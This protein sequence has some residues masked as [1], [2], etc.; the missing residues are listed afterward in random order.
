LH[1]KD[2]NN[3]RFVKL[4]SP[5]KSE[6]A[7]VTKQHRANGWQFDYSK[8][9]NAFKVYYEPRPITEGSGCP[10][11][12][13]RDYRS[14]LLN[15]PWITRNIDEACVVV[16]DV[17]TDYQFT[18]SCEDDVS[19]A[20]SQTRYWNWS[21]LGAGTN[22]LM[23]TIHDF[24]LRGIES[25]Y[26]IPKDAKM[27]WLS[28]GFTKEEFR[29]GFDLSNVL[30]IS[31]NER[32]LDMYWNLTVHQTPKQFMQRPL[33]ASFKGSRYPNDARGVM[34]RKVHNITDNIIIYT[35]CFVLNPNY[36]DYCLSDLSTYKNSPSMESLLLLSQFGLCPRGW[37]L[38]SY[39]FIETLLL[40][41]IPVV[42]A[43][44]YVM[45]YVPEIDWSGCV[46]RLDENQ[47]SEVGRIIKSISARE[48]VKRYS[49]CRRLLTMILTN[50][51]QYPHIPRS[52]NLK[53]RLWA[54][55]FR[56]LRKRIENRAI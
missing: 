43:D 53:W 23:I 47:A 52:W 13:Y 15:Q 4:N 19:K 20:V 12:F 35:R 48:K 44:N 21:S 18:G 2:F 56:F 41:A 28:I 36:D 24:T 11:D 38:A 14:F 49:E 1:T 39:R 46:V 50:D 33:L 5:N 55:V 8:C 9:K 10:S 22:H 51:N 29:L 25:S 7:A 17:Y 27:M 45:P 54:N 26:N 37:G 16:P 34:Q 32:F 6:I 42:I 30:A 3:E 31:I 40:G